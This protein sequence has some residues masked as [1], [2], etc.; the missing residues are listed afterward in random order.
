MWA[1]RRAGLSDVKDSGFYRGP[2]PSAG[3]APSEYNLVP[4]FQRIMN[5]SNVK[6][7]ETLLGFFLLSLCLCL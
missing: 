1:M 5:F 4:S 6:N 2:Y 3:I 7:Y